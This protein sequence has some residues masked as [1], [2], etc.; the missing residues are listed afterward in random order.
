MKKDKVVLFSPQIETFVSFANNVDPSRLQ[1]ASKQL[2]QVVVSK[3]T[4]TPIIIDKYYSSLSEISSPYS[5]IAE[6]NGV[7][8]FSKNEI[9]I[10][11][12]TSEKRMIFKQLPKFKKL[13]NNSLSLKYNIADYKKSFK[14][15]DL[16]F[17]YTNMIPESNLPK[18][19][20][21]TNILFSSFSNYKDVNE[22][23]SMFYTDSHNISI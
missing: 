20:Y 5:E 1:M 8:L 7:V 22:K 21:R 23:T 6:D 15:G 13:I 14:K 18:I 12:Y 11:Y 19:G 16:I 4:D 2:T 10:L 3:Y 17:D 9:L